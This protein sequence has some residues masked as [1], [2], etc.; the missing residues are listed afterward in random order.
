[1]EWTQD[2]LEFSIDGVVHYVYEPPK[3]DSNTWPYDS[4]YYL[5][6]NIA[7]EPDI[8]PE[9]TESAL[10]VDYIRIYQ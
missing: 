6:L 3:K 9:F 5:I 4:E 8:D 7:I 2:K 1:M 10:E